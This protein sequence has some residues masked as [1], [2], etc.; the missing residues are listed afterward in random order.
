M[1]AFYRS[2]HELIFVYKH[3]RSQHR[4]NI[5]LVVCTPT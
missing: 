4:N 5:M 1:G 3:G 2:R